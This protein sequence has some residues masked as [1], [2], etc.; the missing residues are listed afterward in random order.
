MALKRGIVDVHTR[1]SSKSK[2]PRITKYKRV[3]KKNVVDEPVKEQ[4]ST[5]TYNR[6]ADLSTDDEAEMEAINATQAK[7]LEIPKKVKIPP[8]VTIDAKIEDIKKM[9]LDVD[10]TNFNLKFTSLGIKIFCESLTDFKKV[11]D[12]LKMLKWQFFTHD[13]QSA[14]LTKFVL[15]G[16]PVMEIDDVKAGLLN[17]E[18]KFVDVKIMR[19][20]NVNPSH[21]LYL[22]YFDNKSITL[23]ELSRTKYLNHVVI[24]WS[25][26]IQAR[27]GPTQC[28]NCQLYGHGV[29]NCHLSPKCAKCGKSHSTNTCIKDQQSNAEFIPKCCLCGQS[30]SSKSRDCPKRIDY[31]Q[32]R[33]KQ[34]K[35]QRERNSKQMEPSLNATNPAT[36][37]YITP[38]VNSNQK[39]SDWFKPSTETSNANACTNVEREPMTDDLLPNEIL[40]RMMKE[41]FISLRNCRSK[42]DQLEAVTGI[43]LKYSTSTHDV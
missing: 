38:K 21:A 40:L 17:A 29:K 28:N 35:Q 9:L 13:V 8:I 19:T 39:Y 11:C 5:Q 10:V 30:H 15:S 25:V 42:F 26:Y 4:S 34:S 2:F 41:L 36:K 6:Y 1:Q 14:K 20:K 23:Q 37:T 12:G 22:V 31:I 33:L 18:I 3:K 16:L 7:K 27:N 43:V 32:M 24:K